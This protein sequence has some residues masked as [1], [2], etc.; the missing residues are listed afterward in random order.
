MIWPP[1]SPWSPWWRTNGKVAQAMIKLADIKASDII[2][3]LGCGDGTLL[4]KAAKLKHASGVGLEIDPSRVC[5]AKARAFLGGVSKLVLIKRKDLFSEDISKASV[6]V[7]Y[8]VPKT[9]KRL[10]SKFIKELKPG[11]KVI[12]YVYP[13]DYLPFIDRDEKKQINLYKI[14]NSTS[15]KKHLSS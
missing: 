10:E 1:D 14:P 3:D 12:S 6:V 9:L 2:Y 11:T 4:L 8:L 5:I 13:I 15:K 7:V